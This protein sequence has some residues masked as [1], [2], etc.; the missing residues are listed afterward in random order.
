[1]RPLMHTC[2]IALI[3]AALAA[4]ASAQNAPTAGVNTEAQ[5]EVNFGATRAE[6]NSN[7]GAQVKAPLQDNAPVDVNVNVPADARINAETPALRQNQPVDREIRHERREENREFRQ[8]AREA[9][10]LGL[11][12]D[13]NAD[14]I[15]IQDVTR[16]SAAARMGLRRGDRIVRYNNR[17][18]NDH[19]AFNEALMN[20]PRDSQ[21]TIVYERGGQQYT[22]TMWLGEQP[23]QQTYAQNGRVVTSDPYM[24]DSYQSQN[25]VTMKPVGDNLVPMAT[26]TTGYVMQSSC[27]C[28]AAPAPVVYPQPIY[29]QAD[30][31]CG[32]PVYDDCGCDGRRHRRVRRAHRGGCCW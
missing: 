18:F 12:I 25:R 29:P 8:E 30:C 1:M 5:S 20:T 28:S 2:G 9:N 14:N 17:D 24:Q 26:G 23:Q 3:T 10:Q 13:Q 11:T 21:A 22:R 31:G 27:G 7:P 32:Q 15:V 4:T 6:Q 16:D 19:Q